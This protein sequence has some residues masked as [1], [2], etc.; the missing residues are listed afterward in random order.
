[1]VSTEQM[2]L[3]SK[4]LKKGF[5]LFVAVSGGGQVVSVLTFYAG[6]PISN[7]AEVFNLFCVKEQNRLF[8]LVTE[9]SR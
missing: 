4:T 1:M 2:H 8:N 9:W 3:F 7:P 5:K 6:D